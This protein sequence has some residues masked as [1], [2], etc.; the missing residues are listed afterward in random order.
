MEIAVFMPHI[1]AL[2][3]ALMYASVGKLSSGEPFEIKKFSE[4]IAVALTAVIGI[5]LAGYLAEVDLSMLIVAL[6]TV[7]AA[8]VMKL[9]S[10]LQKKRAGLI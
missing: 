9:Y 4:T 6:P 3:V 8:L 5:A 10:Y 1:I 2:V 7:L